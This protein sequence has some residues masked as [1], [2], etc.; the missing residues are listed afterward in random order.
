[1]SWWQQGA[2]GFLGK[3]T[4]FAEKAKAAASSAADVVSTAAAQAAEQAQASDFLEK[5]RTAATTAADA[6]SKAAEQAQAEAS[7]VQALAEAELRRNFLEGD[8][9]VFEVR[10]ELIVIEFPSEDKITDLSARLNRDHAQRMLIY[11]MSERKYDAS[12]FNG[13]VVDVAF[14]GLPAPPLMLLMELCLSAHHWLASDAQNVL[15][16]HCFMG[17]SRSAVFLSCFLAFRGLH[18]HPVD[19]LHE[20]CKSLRIDDAHTVLPSQ[21]RYLTYFQQCNQGMTPSLSRLRFLRASLNGIPRL[22]SEGP[23]AMF[24]YIEVWNQGELVYSSFT[25][26]PQAEGEGDRPTAVGAD[27]PSVQFQLPSSVI[28][29]GDVLVRLRHVRQDG[30]RETA[31][32]LAFNTAFVPEGLQLAKHELDGAADDARFPEESFLDLAFEPVADEGGSDSSAAPPVFQKAFEVS[33][34]L[35]Q[36]E[37]KRR[38]EERRR[39]EEEQRR[40]E[41]ERARVEASVKGPDEGDELEETLRRAAAGV[42]GIASENRKGGGGSADGDAAALRAALAE[43]A[44]DDKKASAAAAAADAPDSPAS[45]GKPAPGAAAAGDQGAKLVEDL[46]KDSNNDIDALFSEFDAALATVGTAAPAAAE[47]DAAAPPAPAASE[48]SAPEAPEPAAAS[49]AVTPTAPAAAETSAAAGTSAAP[50]P[51]EASAASTKPAAPAATTA[52]YPTSAAAAAPVAPTAP[53]AP[54]APA[55]ADPV[56]PAPAKPAAADAPAAA[57]KSASTA[58]GSGDGAGKKD[59]IFAD[60]DA[61]LA[62]LEVPS[63]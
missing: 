22:E 42:S 50:A 15:V 34:R 16:V 12:C 17:F 7:R 1:M 29:T 44:A 13:E 45:A 61:F 35:R 39:L 27:E 6:V 47:V 55:A 30:S 59:D 48:A 9:Q 21:R 57:A 23:V 56:D 43:A 54:A 19:A 11:N 8:C 52:G 18:A 46:V 31:C 28:I 26:R 40:L 2:G 53:V 33:K 36:E 24:P 63:K 5:A 32:R 37:E 10:P 60:M 4:E 58:G 62:E 3:A 20:V 41:R 49:A 14:R 25:G 38:E 51:A